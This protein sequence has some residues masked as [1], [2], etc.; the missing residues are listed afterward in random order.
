MKK[1][2]IL[3]VDDEVTVTRGLKLYLEGTGAYEV[4]AE[5]S[6]AR[7]L[8]SAKEFKPD[9]IVLDVIMP[10]VDGG[11]VAAQVRE[12]NNLKD[13]PI[14][15]LTAIVSK[16]EVGAPALT[17]GG[18]PYIAKPASPKAVIACIEK[19]LS[20]VIPHNEC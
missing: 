11:S 7:A 6:G 2:R 13:T 4:R 10:E 19:T 17:I 14:I 5:N 18:N 16:E 12:D 8:A 15:F 9:L 3:I 1:K 20:Q